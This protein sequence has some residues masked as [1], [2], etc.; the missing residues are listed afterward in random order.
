MGVGAAGL[1]LGCG[2][3][4][5]TTS[6][7]IAAEATATRRATSTPSPT[8]TPTLVPTPTPR[9]A[10]NETRLF[11]AGSQW[12]TT[13]VIRSSGIAGPAL[14]VLGGVHGNEP[15]GWMAGE[16]VAN[17]APQRGVVAVLPRANEIAI[18]SFL[19]LVEGEG[20]LN[21]QYPGDAASEL[22]MSRLAAEITALARELK[23]EL[24]LDLHESWA[25]YVD[26][27]AAGFTSRQQAGTAF[28]GQ[29]VTGGVGPRGA[30]IASELIALVNPLLATEREHLIAR[31]G[32]AF[33]RND[34]P[35]ADSNRG[36]SSLS[37]GGHVE[38]L[39]PVL[40]EMGQQNQSIERRTGMHRIV[41]RAT[42]DI[43]GI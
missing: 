24:L 36:R 8:A 31:D 20:D 38:G 27:E 18:R 22:P 30:E 42:M 26:R 34:A 41:V 15:G 17:W 39:T 35:P 23:P 4:S 28:L 1:V 11:M 40:V 5:D 19:R 3:D 14:M 7:P 25:F 21:R 33:Q 29:T 13:V 2:G 16:E 9:P 12:E 37:L 10:G 6:A 32:S 43:L